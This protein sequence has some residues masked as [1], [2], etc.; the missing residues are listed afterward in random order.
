MTWTLR[1]RIHGQQRRL[2]LGQ[3]PRVTL[4]E[5]R[6]QANQELRKVDGG[7]DPQA[8]REAATRAVEA[9]KLAAE[10]ANRDSIETLCQAYIERHAKPRNGPRNQNGYRS[11]VDTLG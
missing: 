4:A 5:A 7:I 11:V 6:K 1:Y 3:Y 9:A 10:L 2:K 8:E